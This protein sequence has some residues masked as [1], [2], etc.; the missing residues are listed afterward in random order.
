MSGRQ[1]PGFDHRPSGRGDYPVAPLGRMDRRGA[2]FLMAGWEVLAVTADAIT[3]RRELAVQRLRR[4]P[5]DATAA[6]DA[7]RRNPT[8]EPSPFDG[9]V[10]VGGAGGFEQDTTGH[11]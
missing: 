9:G 6:W 3:L 5:T 7:L 8:A 11:Q 1:R 2:A 4:R 10:G